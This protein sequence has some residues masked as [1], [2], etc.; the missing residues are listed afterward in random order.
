MNSECVFTINEITSDEWMKLRNH[1][2]FPKID[3]AVADKALSNSIAVIG[4][5]NAI[6]EH[7]GMLRIIG[8]SIYSF[9]FN[10]V[11]ILP[12]YQNMGLGT[13][14]VRFAIDFLQNKYCENSMFSVSIFSNEDAV[15]FYMKSGFTV[16]K[17]TPMKIYVR[18]DIRGTRKMCSKV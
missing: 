4:V 1:S 7:I 12:D 11:I 2:G 16:E 9:Y 10:D 3:N 17:E 15:E 13:R 5:R 6:G 14:M 18:G 8:D